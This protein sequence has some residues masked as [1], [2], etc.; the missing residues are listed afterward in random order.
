MG[1]EMSDPGHG[2]GKKF[3]KK[4]PGGKSASAVEAFWQV[5]GI[6]LAVGLLYVVA[7][8]SERARTVPVESHTISPDRTR[9]EHTV[10]SR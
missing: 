10:G 7:Q 6:A 2:S 5:V 4:K 1:L 9:I 8:S 3:D